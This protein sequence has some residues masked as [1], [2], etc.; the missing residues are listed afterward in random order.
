VEMTRKKTRRCISHTLQSPCPYCGGSGKVLST[1]TTLLKVRKKLM[2]CFALEESAAYL[3]RVHPDVARLIERA[4]AE[5][6][7][8]PR[9]KGRNLW[10]QQ[11]AALHVEEFA[12]SPIGPGPELERIKAQAKLY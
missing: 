2:S 11:D 8:L 12:V 5:E 6:P 4:D 3:L 10:I 1:E 7:I 9:Q